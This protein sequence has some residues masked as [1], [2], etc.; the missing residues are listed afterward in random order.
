VI[1]VSDASPLIAL[2]GAGQA[3]RLRKLYMS[4]Y[5]FIPFPGFLALCIW[6]DRCDFF[7]LSFKPFSD[8]YIQIRGRLNCLD[9]CGWPNAFRSIRVWLN[10][11]Q[12]NILGCRTM[13][14]E[15][16][17]QLGIVLIEGKS[18]ND[19]SLRPG[20]DGCGQP[21]LV[22]QFLRCCL[23]MN[24]RNNQGVAGQSSSAIGVPTA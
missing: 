1:V 5:V 17:Q 10:I 19:D 6:A 4:L 2:T 11:Y 22:G 14:L 12:N 3:E 24:W 9:E 18:K 23:A 20:E 7:L 8:S 16:I 21:P 13:D 15:V